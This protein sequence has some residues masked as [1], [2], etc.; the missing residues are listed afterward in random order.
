MPPPSTLSLVRANLDDQGARHLMLL[1]VSNAALGL[2]FD[3]GT[4]SHEKTEIIFGSDFPLD[5]SDLQVCVD[6]QVIDQSYKCGCF[7]SKS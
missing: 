1:T 3:R 2:V 7:K 4:L 6:I 5:Q